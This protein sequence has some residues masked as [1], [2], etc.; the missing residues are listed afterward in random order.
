MEGELGD[1]SEKCAPDR[2]ASERP[3]VDQIATSIVRLTEAYLGD[4]YKTKSGCS[5]MRWALRWLN[6]TFG[7]VTFFAS[8]LLVTSLAPAQ[9]ADTE[10]SRLSVLLDTTVGRFGIG[11]A[12]LGFSVLLSCVIAQSIQRGGPLRLFISGVIISSLSFVVTGRMS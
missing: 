4:A 9:I 6:A 8:M 10:L 3:A 11:L 12:V 1:G 5:Q 2:G 7:I